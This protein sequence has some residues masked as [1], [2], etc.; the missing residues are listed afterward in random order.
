V[1]GGDLKAKRRRTEN[2]TK[3]PF[4]NA[5]QKGQGKNNSRQRSIEQGGTGDTY[6]KAV[7]GNRTLSRKKSEQIQHEKL[8]RKRGQGPQS[9]EKKKSWGERSYEVSKNRDWKGLSKAYQWRRKKN[10]GNNIIGG[11]KDSDRHE[12]KRGDW[13]QGV[14][15][16]N[17]VSTAN[18]PS[19]KRIIQGG[20]T[21]A[22]KMKLES[23]EKG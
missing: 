7:K 5:D 10:L 12:K 1:E 3:L 20:K 19:E 15:K 17:K 4:E 16:R 9:M 18:Y 21:Q 6:D 11:K 13:G 2:R 8:V 22:K 14:L 23:A